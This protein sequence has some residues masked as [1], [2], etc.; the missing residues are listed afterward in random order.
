MDLG[1]DLMP[2]YQRD[3][4]IRSAEEN[5]FKVWKWLTQ[6]VAKQSKQS[7]DAKRK[8]AMIK[9][10]EDALGLHLLD[11]AGMPKSIAKGKFG[12]KVEVHSVRTTRRI[13]PDGQDIRQLVIEVAQKRA[14]Y[15]D[16]QVQKAM[17]SGKGK[18]PPEDFTFRGGATLIIDLRE[19]TPRLRYV[20]R[21]RIESESRLQDQRELLGSPA[22]F[23]FTYLPGGTANEP[24]AMLHRGVE[25]EEASHG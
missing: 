23:G 4:I 19:F 10:W 7:G 24:F 8:I 16:P 17:D 6:T 9:E 18:P 20:I 21:K 11:K 25:H 1:L 12:P 3:Y 22:G 13:G 15:F 14:G 2:H 5:R